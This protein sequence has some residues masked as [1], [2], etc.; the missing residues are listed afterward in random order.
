MLFFFQKLF[1][2]FGSSPRR[3]SFFSKPQ[4]ELPLVAVFWQE[5]IAF[6]PVGFPLQSGLVSELVD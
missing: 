3:A 4:N 5:K 1:P 6:S 2:L